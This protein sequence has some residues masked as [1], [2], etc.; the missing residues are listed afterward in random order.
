MTLPN[1][2][3]I[4]AAKAGTSSV[5]AY[6]GQH[7]DVFIS[8]TKE[9]NY[10]ALA[11]Q[12]V[13][14][15]GPG[16]SIINRASITRLDAYEALFKS[17]RK[18]MAVGEA[19]TLYLYMPAAAEAIQRLIPDVRLVAILRDPAE[20]AYS[21]YLHMRR[22]GREPMTTFED[23]LMEEETR[24]SNDWEHLWHY[25]RLGFYYSQLKRYYDRF[26]REQIGVW[27][28]EDLE[29][30]PQRVLQEVFAFLGV[31][32]TFVPD[33]SIRHKV[34]GT[35]RSK[36]LHAA[37][38]QPNA[39]KALVKRL[40]PSRVRGHLYGTLMQKNIVSH[41]EELQPA[42][43]RRLQ[44]LYRSDVESLSNLLGRDLSAWLPD[45]GDFPS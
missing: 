34:A 42:V 32:Q 12:E 10:F 26:P 2:L 43:R 17:A 14:F 29:S 9:P 27:L 1:F 28:Y 5:F 30:D 21:S 13:R 35:P 24:I 19:S 15:A 18:G 31:D 23:A 37:L 41:R 16:D 11:G 39:A 3:L 38:T 33:M 22:D 44:T 36:A 4:G 8:P 45:R 7:P 6:L 20:R 40:L 25:S